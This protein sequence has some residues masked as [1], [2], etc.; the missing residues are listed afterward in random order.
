[1]SIQFLRLPALAVLACIALLPAI[2]QAGGDDK[3]PRATF[4]QFIVKFKDGSAEHGNASARQR[5]LDVGVKGKGVHA[6]RNFRMGIGADVVTLDGPLNFR[7]A[8]DFMNRLRRNPNVQYVEIDRTLKP[9]FTPNDTS[10]AAQWHYYEAVGGINM[11]AAW[12]QSTGS[13]VVVAVL[14]TGITVHTDLAA[15]IVAGYDFIANFTR[16][17]DGSGRDPDPSDPGDWVAL[18]EC[19]GGNPAEDSTWHGTHVSGTIAEVTNN[20]KGL[21]GVA[22]N[23]RVMPVRVLGK[24]GGK[25]TDI[26]DAILWAAGGSIVGVPAN[27]NPVEVINMSLGGAGACSIAT[28]TAI[29][30]AVTHGVVVVVAAGN[31]DATAASYE[32]ANCNNVIVV[33]ATQR[34]G[35]RSAYSNYGDVVDVSAPGGD[36]STV[37]ASY[38]YSTFNLGKTVPAGEG[39]AGYTGTSMATPHVAGTVALMQAAAVTTPAN[40]EAVLKSTARAFPV[41]CVQTGGCGTGIIDASAAV[42]TV[43][44]GALTVADVGISEGNAGPK[45]L[46]FTVSLSKAMPT[47][48]TFDV[49]TANGTASAGSDYM[50]LALTGQSIAAGVTSKTFNV[51]INGDTAVELDETFTF[52][53][54]NVTGILVASG[55][56]VGTIINDDATALVNGV[57]VNGIAA[58]IRSYL[59]YSLDVPA[60]RTSVTFTSSGGTGDA[61]LYGK[62]GSIP[63]P[64]NAD[65][66]SLGSTNAESCVINTPAAGTYYVM[67]YAYATISGLTLVGTYV[68][69]ASPT[70]NVSDASVTEGNAGTKLLGFTVNL[71]S[72]SA[73]PV[74]F[75]LATYPGTA[76]PGVD[77]APSSAVGVSIPAGQTSANF[78]VTING[79]TEIE[80]N[81]TFTVDASNI[82]GALAGNV[83]GLGRIINDDQAQLRIADASIIEG[84]NGLST[85]VFDVV[86]SQPM[87][88]PVTF[89]IATS[90]GTATAGSDYVARSQAG[91]YLDAGRS[92]VQ[93]EVIVNGDA[94]AEP[95]ETI[96][97]TVSNVNGALLAD[98]AAVGTI[99]NDD[100]P[101]FVAGG[102]LSAQSVLVSPVLL[103][104]DG[105]PIVDEA[106]ACRPAGQR[107]GRLEPKLPTCAR[108]DNAA[109]HSAQR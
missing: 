99:I 95:D 75:D 4:D 28:Q 90:N 35:G 82:N 48:V 89:D 55:Q 33:G 40:V 46:T 64:A 47:P 70:V 58:P 31:D 59:L 87:P 77:Y 16:A 102:T 41:P 17:N 56:A 7:G 85:L 71:T 74:T 84:N 19:P 57:A 96:N 68:P 5:A 52:N 93:F 45:V 18:D 38:V 27:P 104:F 61:D 8:E 66:T 62:L 86:L 109:G 36:G 21:A 91:R 94:S 76:I 78:N 22:F 69:D 50:A 2:A 92:R 24:C 15:N 13:G 63:G 11:P 80:D 32:P 29:D 10:Y 23:A 72:V 44:S 9:T 34:L 81:E 106:V 100:G 65:C 107:R 39:Y 6:R 67:V 88:S 108:G 73:N 14:D 79:D 83:Q 103:G 105:K 51:T 42:G 43:G 1:M 37:P 98:G 30:Y 12:A 3:N 60:G 20:S 54:S 49:A 26:A 101:G 97:V 25:E 53:V